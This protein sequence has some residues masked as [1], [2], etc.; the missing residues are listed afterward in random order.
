[1][2]RKKRKG[3][4]SPYTEKLRG[5]FG[6]FGSNESKIN[7]IQLNMPV[8]KIEKLGL[9]SEI[10]G[11]ERW[12][13][14]QL[15][16]RDIDKDRVKNE[17]IPYFLDK[18]TAK[19]FNPLTIAVLPIS[20][21]GKLEEKLSEKLVDVDEE[22]KGDFSLAYEIDGFYKVSYDDD[23]FSELKWNPSQVKLVA[24][25]GQH[26]LHALKRLYALYNQNPANENLTAVDFISWR[27]P[28]V[29]VTIG[30]AS[31]GET[32]DGIL[33]KTRN[34]F[35]TINKQAKQPTRSRTI[36]LNDY[37][38]S[39]ICSQEVL[40]KSRSYNIPLAIFNWRDHKDEH[41][42]AHS[43]HL[44]AVDE[45]E[46]LLINFLVGEDD[47]GDD[48]LAL[49]REQRA[50]LFWDDL[51]DDD[52]DTAAGL[53]E[54]IRQRFGETILPGLVH[55]LNGIRP[56]A[57]YVDFLNNLENELADD[58]EIHAWSRIVY[59]SDY[60][61]DTIEDEV[62][63]SKQA[64]LERCSAAKEQLGSIFSK[65]VGLRS[66]FSA[67]RIFVDTI[68]NDYKVIPWAEAANHFITSFNRLFDA[69]LIEND[70]FVYNI[71]KDNSG[72][73]IINYKVGQVKGAYGAIIAYAC[74]FDYFSGNETDTV[75]DVKAK[76]FNTL[77]RGYKKD[78]RPQVKEE[79]GNRPNDEINEEVDSRA[80]TAVRAQIRE[81][82]D[83][84][85]AFVLGGE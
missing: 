12:P 26:R 47:N 61:D 50:A 22:D 62:K 82:D 6:N 42:P 31:E 84:L 71:V 29:V 16:Q 7:Y 25:D 72:D 8:T 59:G 19:F 18:S 51:S 68:W 83:L 54:G 56:Y 73:N 28:I 27:I 53:R 70:K 81:I 17:I 43:T 44:I 33:E 24:I 39:A 5:E 60:A 77:L 40:D 65:A 14:R 11:S 79:L 41:V 37:S 36:L 21:T 64:I 48:S 23:F 46:D 57:S 35:V 74:L 67:F 9:V 30:H 13:I 20:K 32:T 78:L 76:I 3:N 2:P 85:K 75:L 66:I 38:V 34:I 58:S 63:K 55:I 1:M 80:N 4:D 10:P 69:G 49:S 45:L 52:P 15:F